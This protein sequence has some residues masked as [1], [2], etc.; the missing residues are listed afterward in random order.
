MRRDSTVYVTNEDKEELIK[1]IDAINEIL[2]KYPYS[3]DYSDH[4][5]T[6]MSRAK[7]FSKDAQKW[8]GYLDVQ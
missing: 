5:V 6:T 4:F 2:N 7:S 1:Y 3:N 8:I